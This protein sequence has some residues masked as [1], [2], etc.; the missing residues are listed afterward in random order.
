MTIGLPYWETIFLKNIQKQMPRA[1]INTG[2]HSVKEKE[3]LQQDSIPFG[4]TDHAIRYQYVSTDLP[5]V[6]GRCLAGQTFRNELLD[7]S[8]FLY[9]SCGRRAECIPDGQDNL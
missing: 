2:G 8:A 3:A 4:R 6:S 5:D 1:E 9:G 7:D